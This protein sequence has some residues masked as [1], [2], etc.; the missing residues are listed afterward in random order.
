MSS[1]THPEDVD[2]TVDELAAR[3]DVSVRT[4]R[5]YAGKRLLPPPRLSGRTGLYGPHHLARLALIRDLT[6]AGYTLAAVTQFMDSLPEG[7]DPEAVRLFGTLLTPWVAEEPVRWTHAELA[8]ALDREVDDA[9]IAQLTQAEV[10]TPDAEGGVS[11]TPSQL[12]M[13]RRLL[14]LDAPL[15]ALIEAGQVIREHA[16]RLAEDLQ[17]I[18]R[19]RIMAGSASDDG[20]E[21]QRLRALSAALRPLT[22]QSIVTAYTEALEREVREGR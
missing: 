17:R 7:A 11:L 15:D 21:R 9:L 2:L 12:E 8:E 18:F 4:V 6:D 1:P 20:E 22:I 19:T 10:L 13:G 5:F 3:A 14:A 16:G